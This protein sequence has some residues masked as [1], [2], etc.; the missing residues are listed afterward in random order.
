MKKIIYRVPLFIIFFLGVICVYA[1]LISFLQFFKRGSIA[2]QPHHVLPY[3]GKNT[4]YD[5]VLM[6]TSHGRQFSRDLNH[7]KVE[8]ILQR[9]TA[10]LATGSGGFFPESVYLNTFLLD[11]N[12]ADL[13]LYFLDPLAFYFT[14]T[15]NKN[16]KQ[17]ALETLNISYLYS[18][19]KYNA[20]EKLIMEYIQNNLLLK[21]LFTKRKQHDLAGKYSRHLFY[22]HGKDFI[23]R[24]E[25]SEVSGA[26]QSWYGRCL[27]KEKFCAD[28]KTTKEYLFSENLG[29]FNDLLALL[30]E[31]KSKTIM[32]IPPLLFEDLYPVN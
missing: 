8:K 19:Y 27:N 30:R 5:L 1:N 16:H 11:G 24:A 22:L 25:P 23:R 3:L 13:I 17:L 18:L 10:N 7:R 9:K 2:D 20:S 21:W 14:P 26:L 15:S 29:Y 6:G 4:H 12:K 31:S 32:V 28:M